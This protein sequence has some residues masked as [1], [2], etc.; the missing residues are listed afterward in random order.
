MQEQVVVMS[1]EQY[2]KKY[3]VEGIGKG[4][5]RWMV[6]RQMVEAFRKEIFGLVAMRAKKNFEDIPL[7]GDPEASR[8]AKNVIHDATRKWKK[9]CDMF[10]RYQE[11]QNLIGPHD[12]K[13]YDEIDD[14]GTTSEEA[15]AEVNGEDGNGSGESE[16]GNDGKETDERADSYPEGSGGNPDGVEDDEPKEVDEQKGDT[17]EPTV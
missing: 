17:N 15:N 12:L 6:K 13:L 16:S 14:I 11:T 10:S 8:I 3:A 5:D 2:F 4:A 1:A 7:E 9:L